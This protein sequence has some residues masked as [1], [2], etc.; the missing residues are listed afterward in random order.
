VG[1]KSILQSKR[2]IVPT[3]PGT[4]AYRRRC[5]RWSTP[6]CPYPQTA[7]YNGSGD[8]NNAAH[9]HGGG[10]LETA[11]TVCADVLTKYKHEAKGH[12]DYTGTGVNRHVCEAHDHGHHGDD[13]GADP[14]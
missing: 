13:D 12:L 5:P 10:N 11:P 3:A 4:A 9:F 6:L 7:I 8:T 2:G 14:D 1:S